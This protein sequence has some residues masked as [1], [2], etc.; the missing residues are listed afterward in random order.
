MRPAPSFSCRTPVARLESLLES[1][2]EQEKPGFFA[3]PAPA[4]GT[5]SQRLAPPPAPHLLG[6]LTALS[7]ECFFFRGD[8]VAVLPRYTALLPSVPDKLIMS[9]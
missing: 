2:L 1:R 7:V 9:N 6:C 3:K 4:P 5:G 8:G